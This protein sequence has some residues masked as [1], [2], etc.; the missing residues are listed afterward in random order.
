MWVQI[1]LLLQVRFAL[2]PHMVTKQGEG[3]DQGEQPLPIILDRLN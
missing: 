1:R 3:D 2:D